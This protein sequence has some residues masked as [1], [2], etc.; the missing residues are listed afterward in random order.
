MPTEDYGPLSISAAKQEV[1]DSAPDNTSGAITEA[2]ARKIWLRQYSVMQEFFQQ[3]AA[4]KPG[5]RT[6]TATVDSQ[7]G[8]SNAVPAGGEVVGVYRN[9]GGYYLDDTEYVLQTDRTLLLT[10]ATGSDPIAKDERLTVHYAQLPSAVTVWNRTQWRVNAGNLEYSYD[11]A[12]WTV[13]G[14]MPALANALTKVA[15]V[16]AAGVANGSFDKVV[17]DG[18]RR[19]RIKLDG[20]IIRLTGILD[21]QL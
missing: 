2:V 19:I 6:L 16:T 15:D 12:T 9:S 3:I 1:R 7:S 10:L 11:G 13:A 14:A 20:E 18:E 5:I 17:V 4:I 8:F 21:S